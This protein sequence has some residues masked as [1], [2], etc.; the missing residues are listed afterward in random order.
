[1]RDLHGTPVHLRRALRGFAY[2][3]ASPGAGLALCGDGFGAGNE[4]ARTAIVAGL[5]AARRKLAPLASSGPART[6]RPTS[7][8]VTER[9]DAAAVQARRLSWGR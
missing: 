1:M 5:R 3:G 9:C 7:R 2:R 4:V 8:S 6:A